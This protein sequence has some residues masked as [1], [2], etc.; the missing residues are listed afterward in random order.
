MCCR[1]RL[2]TTEN[3]VEAPALAPDKNG[4]NGVTPFLT[5][6]SQNSAVKTALRFLTVKTKGLISFEVMGVRLR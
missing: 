3:E 5:G 4:A 1:E 2:W 6:E